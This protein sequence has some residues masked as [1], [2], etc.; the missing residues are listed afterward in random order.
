[1]KSCGSS[2]D[3]LWFGLYRSGPANIP[4]SWDSESNCQGVPS[5]APFLA[6]QVTELFILSRDTRAA[7]NLFPVDLHVMRFHQVATGHEKLFVF[8]Q[9]SVGGSEAIARKVQ[10]CIVGVGTNNKSF[11]LSCYGHLECNQNASNFSILGMI[12]NLD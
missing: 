5:R 3:K 6:S 7:S 8:G 11:Y 1:M 2:G 10:M 9:F 12:E 4:Q